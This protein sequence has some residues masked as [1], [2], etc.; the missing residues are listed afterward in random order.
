MTDEHC[1]K[2]LG[3]DEEFTTDNYKITTCPKKEFE[4]AMGVQKCPESDLK[5]LRGK[6]VREIKKLDKL[7][8]LPIAKKLIVLEILA[9]VGLF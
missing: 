4:I 7:K 1:E 5:D 3:S 2:D 6:C 8:R 9:V